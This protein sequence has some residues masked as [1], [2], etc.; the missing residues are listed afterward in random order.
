MNNMKKFQFQVLDPT[1]VVVSEHEFEYEAG[2][3]NRIAINING[4]IH[5]F[6]HDGDYLNNINDERIC[7]FCNK[8]MEAH[9]KP[10]Y[11]VCTN[12]HCDNYIKIIK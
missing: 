12:P 8:K 10:D 4:N 1:G 3:G 11:H 9:P 5:A 2:Y 6:S 7:K